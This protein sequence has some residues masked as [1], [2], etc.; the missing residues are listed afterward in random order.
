MDE[1]DGGVSKEAS[2]NCTAEALSGFT[3]AVR[4]ALLCRTGTADLCCFAEQGRR[5]SK[6]GRQLQAPTMNVCDVENKQ[7]LHRSTNDECSMLRTSA[8]ALCS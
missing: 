2:K 6:D 5:T 7:K 8:G 3:K 4:F 1:S